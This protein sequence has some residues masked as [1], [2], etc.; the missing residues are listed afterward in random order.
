LVF[1]LNAQEGRVIGKPYEGKPH[2]RFDEGM[3]VKSQ[4]ETSVLL[5]TSKARGRADSVRI[6]IDQ[7]VKRLR[8]KSSR[9][10]SNNQF[11]F[12]HLYT[13]IIV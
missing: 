11:I 12:N 13:H 8:F 4:E 5:Y 6:P 1:G 10:N 3:L 2:V 9:P 7:S